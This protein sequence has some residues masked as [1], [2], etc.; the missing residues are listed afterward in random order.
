MLIVLALNIIFCIASVTV[1]LSNDVRFGAEVSRKRKALS[2]C[3]TNPGSPYCQN[4]S[5][6]NQFTDLQNLLRSKTRV[7]SVLPHTGLRL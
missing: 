7:Q 3:W 4:P 1:V 5:I 2:E 6:Q